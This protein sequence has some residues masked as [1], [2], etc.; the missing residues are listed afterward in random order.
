ME[1]EAYIAPDLDLQVG[2]QSAV[3]ELIDCLAVPPAVHVGFSQAQGGPLQHAVVEPRVVDLDVPGV[4]A[5]DRNARQ[6]EQLADD[7]F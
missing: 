5:V 1:Q 6:V 7:R 3:D 2:P 4:A